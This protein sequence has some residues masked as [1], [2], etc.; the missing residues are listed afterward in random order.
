MSRYLVLHGALSFNDSY[1]YG[2]DD[3]VGSLLKQTF[4]KSPGI[5]RNKH[6]LGLKEHPVILLNYLSSLNFRIVSQSSP[7]DRAD[8]VIWTLT[9][10]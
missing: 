4:K 6:C 8:Q 2:H 10:E 9:R 7:G 1:I 3:H 5:F